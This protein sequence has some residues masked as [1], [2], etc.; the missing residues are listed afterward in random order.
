M[1]H[2]TLEDLEIYPRIPRKLAVRVLAGVRETEAIAIMRR[3]LAGEGRLVVLF[4]PAGSGK[5]IAA[6]WACAASH[7][8]AYF[9][10][11]DFSELRDQGLERGQEGWFQ[12]RVQT[13]PLIVIDDWGTEHNGPARYAAGR[14]EKA[15]IER[16]AN[17]LATVLTTNMLPSDARERYGERIAS[18]VNGDGLGWHNLPAI[19]YR[20]QR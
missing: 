15:I 12:K 5:S 17:D 9:H 8:A 13:F 19:D 3:M 2:R 16:D 4:G 1:S 7:G 20:S 10:A 18:R 14:I 11:G 6:A